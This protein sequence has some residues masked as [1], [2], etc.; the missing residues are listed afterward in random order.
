MSGGSSKLA[1]MGDRTGM[2]DLI[3][4]A[5][6]LGVAVH[7]AHIERPYVGFYDPDHR[8]VVVDFGLRATR[9]RSVLAHE[10]GHAYYDH[11]CHGDLNAE[12]QADAYAARLLIDP[13]AYS[14]AEAYTLDPEVIADE[15]GVTVKILRAFQQTC[16]TR[17]GSVTYT[18]AKMGVGQWSHRAEAV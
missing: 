10:L 5:A 3:A 4:H 9:L 7:L 8:R 18:A 14:R 17:I 13:E 2:R 11:R 15:L 1:R 16:L 6:G 12:R